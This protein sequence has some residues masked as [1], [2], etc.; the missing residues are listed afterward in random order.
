MINIQCTKFEW[1]FQRN[2][3]N[4]SQKI[5][6]KGCNKT[7]QK[8]VC[9]NCETADSDFV[10]V[11]GLQEDTSAVT[12]FLKE[13]FS[14]Y[15]INTSAGESGSQF[16]SQ[17]FQQFSS[18]WEFSHASSSPYHQKSNGKVEAAVKTAKY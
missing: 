16:T 2:Y 5:K 12:E 10:E 9:T 6:E 13:Q 18:R 11:K 17:K 3:L 4:K 8:R 7:N 1:N 14:R 15:G